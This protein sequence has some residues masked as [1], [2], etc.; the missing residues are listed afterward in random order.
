M[1]KKDIR[2]KIIKYKYKEL[3]IFNI[4]LIDIEALDRCLTQTLNQLF[5]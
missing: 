5:S 1:K 4:K 3:A 2:K